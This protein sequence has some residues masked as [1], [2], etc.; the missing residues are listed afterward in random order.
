[1]MDRFTP[2]ERAEFLDVLA[3]AARDE[4]PRLFCI[5][6]FSSNREVLGW[7]MEWP[8]HDL[9]VYLEPPSHAVHLAGSAEQ[10]LEGFAQIG[11]VNLMWLGDHERV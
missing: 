7:G 4:Q 2:E 8:E 1:M 10:L 11:A 5:Y 6:G 9:C 3:G